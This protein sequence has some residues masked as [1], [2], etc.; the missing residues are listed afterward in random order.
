M[1]DPIF[2]V[3]MQDVLSILSRRLDV[4][5]LSPEELDLARQ[6]VKEAIQHHLD[7]REFI[8]IG[9][10]AWAITRHL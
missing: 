9:L 2:A 5:T 3:T 10:D 8:E 4:S 7:I 1:Q 6:E